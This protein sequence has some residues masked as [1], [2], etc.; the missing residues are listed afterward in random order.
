MLPDIGVRT[1]VIFSLLW[2]SLCLLWYA[3]TF[4]D[5]VCLVVGVAG[6]I[7]ALCLGHTQRWAGLLL[8]F[9][10]ALVTEPN[11]ERESRMAEEITVT[12]AELVEIG[13][14]LHNWGSRHTVAAAGLGSLF[15]VWIAP[16]DWEFLIGLAGACF[17]AVAAYWPAIVTALRERTASK[18]EA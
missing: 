2:L 5:Y 16:E 15:A 7:M 17:I 4:N 13:K 8:D 11:K 10:A 18:A 14:S 3:T 9:L 6:A 12:R 1:R